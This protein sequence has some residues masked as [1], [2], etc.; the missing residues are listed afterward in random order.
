MVSPSG[1]LRNRVQYKQKQIAYRT[2]A[3]AQSNYLKRS[4]ALAALLNDLS[5]TAIPHL[6]LK[7]NG[8]A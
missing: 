1:F 7:N 5:M 8:Y 3:Q 6:A 2:N 4:I